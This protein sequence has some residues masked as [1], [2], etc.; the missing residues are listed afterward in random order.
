MSECPVCHREWKDGEAIA[1]IMR[2]GYMYPAHVRC[3]MNVAGQQEVDGAVNELK[4]AYR[5]QRAARCL[6]QL[7]DFV[8]AVSSKTT[9]S[10]SLL[11]RI[12][13]KEDLC[14]R[15]AEEAYARALSTNMNETD[16][17]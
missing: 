7:G 11:W 15:R 13:N 14:W 10:E 12:D 3:V 5:H 2:D 1:Y 16:T 6:R 17:K 4:R 9:D 8:G